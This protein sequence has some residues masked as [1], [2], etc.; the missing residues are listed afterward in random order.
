MRI[1]VV[2][3]RD[4][5]YP[6][7]R[8]YIGRPSALGNPFVIGRDGEREDVILEYDIWLRQQLAAGNTPAAREFEMLLTFAR[9]NEV[10]L[11]C[12]CAPQACHGDIIKRELEKRP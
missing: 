8:W 10:G 12:W 11:E 3:K 7:K 5:S 9:S 1:V 4:P 2:N 6:G